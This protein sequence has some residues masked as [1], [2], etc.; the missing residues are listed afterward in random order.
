MLRARVILSTTRLD[1]YGRLKFI[2]DPGERQDIFC[3]YISALASFS[4]LFLVNFSFWARSKI[5]DRRLISVL[6]SVADCT[7]CVATAWRAIWKRYSISVLL[8]TLFCFRAEQ[9]DVSNFVIYF[10]QHH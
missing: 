1:V 7:P 2:E 9:E 5:K 8:H 4:S 3:A 10:K 6:E